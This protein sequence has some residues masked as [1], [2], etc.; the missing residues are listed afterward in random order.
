MQSRLGAMKVPR[1]GWWAMPILLFT[2]RIMAGHSFSALQHRP[3]LP[4]VPLSTGPF[5]QTLDP[6]SRIQLAYGD[7]RG[8]A[9]LRPSHLQ[10]HTRHSLYQ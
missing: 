5:F 8:I 9:F 7:T 6:V 4:K 1:D 10:W 3:F 2:V